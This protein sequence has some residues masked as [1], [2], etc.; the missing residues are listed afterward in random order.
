MTN[1]EGITLLHSQRNNLHGLTVGNL[2]LF[3]S[4]SKLIIF[5]IFEE[6]SNERLFFNDINTDH[7]DSLSTTTQN[8]QLQL[9]SGRFVEFFNNSIEAINRRKEPKI[10]KDNLLSHKSD[11]GLIAFL[12]PIV[13]PLLVTAFLIGRYFGEQ[14]IDKDAILLKIENQQLHNANTTLIE[15]VKKTYQ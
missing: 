8:Y 3:V 12:T 15:S 1:K 5:L 13:V 6:G 14:K 10:I 7:I 2:N 4:N 9:I 11:F